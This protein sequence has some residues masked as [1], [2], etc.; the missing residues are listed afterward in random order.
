MYDFLLKFKVFTF[1]GATGNYIKKI[2]ILNSLLLSYRNKIDFCV[3]TSYPVTLLNILILR[4]FRFCSC[5]FLQTFYLDN[6]AVC[7]QKQFNFFLPNVYLP[8]SPAPI[9]P[10][11]TVQCW[12]GVIKVDT[13][14]LFSIIWGRHLVFHNHDISCSFFFFYIVLYQGKK[15]PSNF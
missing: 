8:S 13:L 9:L 10:N 14:A 3:L 1:F 7:D 11:C 12:T 5:R 4:V 6:N 2:S 15:A